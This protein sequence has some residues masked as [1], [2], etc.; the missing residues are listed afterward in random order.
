M[1]GGKPGWTVFCSET[2][3]EVMETMPERAAFFVR[4]FCD[5]ASTSGAAVDSGQAPPGKPL[6]DAGV[7]YNLLV[8]EIHMFIE[9][10]VMA[11]IKEF[12]VTGLVRAE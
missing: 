6:D 12:Y 1:S 3:C 10:V 4:Y 9:Y 11:D 8:E 7:A 2:V 5:F